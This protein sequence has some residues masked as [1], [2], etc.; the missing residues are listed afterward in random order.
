MPRYRTGHGAGYLRRN[1]DVIEYWCREEDYA[2]ACAP[3]GVIP[4]AGSAVY[5]KLLAKE[6]IKNHETVS[7]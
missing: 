7:N 4:I 1:R 3:D 6:A 5:A 2:S